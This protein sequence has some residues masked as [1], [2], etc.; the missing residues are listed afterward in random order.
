MVVGETHH[1]RNPH[2]EISLQ[3]DPFA[4]LKDLDLFHVGIRMTFS[5]PPQNAGKIVVCGNHFFGQGFQHGSNVTRVV[6]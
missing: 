1:F 5:G 6:V 2:A 3:R 4:D